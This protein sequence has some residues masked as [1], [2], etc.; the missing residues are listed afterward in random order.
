M[1][2]TLRFPHTVTIVT[3][4][5]RRLLAAVVI[6]IVTSGNAQTESQFVTVSG[7]VTDVAGTRVRGASIQLAPPAL[8]T[9]KPQQTAKVPLK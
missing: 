5:H 9:R 3:L 8:L 7:T 4:R 1:R 2:S 6:A